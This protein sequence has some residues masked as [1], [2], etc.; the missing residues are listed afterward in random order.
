M[1]SKK[2]IN[3]KKIKV[4]YLVPF[5]KPFI[6]NPIIELLDTNEIDCVIDFHFSIYSFFRNQ[7]LRKMIL[8]YKNDKEIQSQKKHLTFFPGLPKNFLSHYYPVWIS[9]ILINKYRGEKF[10]LIHAHTLLPS[11]FV[12]YKL[13]KKWRIPFIVTSHGMDFYRCLPDV[14]KYRHI[15]LSK[16][17]YIIAVSNNYA[18]QISEYNSKAN[19]KVIENSYNMEIFYKINKSDARNKL[20]ISLNNKILISTG[21]FVKSK[22][23]IYLLQAMNEVIK[24]YPDIKLYIIGGGMLWKKYNEFIKKNNLLNNVYLLDEISQRELALWNNAADIFVFPSISESFGVALIEAMACGIPVI[25]ADSEGPTEI[26]ENYETGIIVN[27]KS[28]KEIAKNIIWLLTDDK[29]RERIS[30]SGINEIQK[31]FSQKNHEYLKLYKDL[32]KQ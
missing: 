32:I 8:K 1:K 25:V 6:Q 12:A 14:N 26:I 24:K 2:I 10:N 3:N 15:V 22:G 31:R 4:L 27:K 7:N 29:L 13:S 21:N 17:N 11:G 9:K 16:S 30:N 18:K 20:S 5:I 28:S 23:H 19:V